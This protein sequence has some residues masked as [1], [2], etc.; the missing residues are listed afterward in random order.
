MLASVAVKQD[1]VLIIKHLPHLCPNH[2]LLHETAI[3]EGHESR[4]F[5]K[6]PTCVMLLFR[7]KNH[8]SPGHARN[9]T[10][11]EST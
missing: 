5:F 11:R 1:V 2:S 3:K 8:T 6:I 4:H 9:I 10:T 7:N